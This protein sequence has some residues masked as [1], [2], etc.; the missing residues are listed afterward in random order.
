MISLKYQINNNLVASLDKI[1]LSL[2]I[3]LVYTSP[4]ITTILDY[5]D[6][7]YKLSE[8]FKKNN[9]LNACTLVDFHIIDVLLYCV[10]DKLNTIRHKHALD[11]MNIEHE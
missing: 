9:K 2:V 3:P 8:L 4:Y 5:V 6:G 1:D 7:L 10:F 11:F